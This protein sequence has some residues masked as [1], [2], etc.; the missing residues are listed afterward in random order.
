MIK[1]QSR[2][3]IDRYR[4]DCAVLSPSKWCHF[5]EEVFCHFK[6]YYLRLNRKES[7]LDL[8]KWLDNQFNLIKTTEKKL[9]LHYIKKTLKKNILVKV[10]LGYN[11][12]STQEKVVKLIKTHSFQLNV[13][14]WKEKRI[15]VYKNCGLHIVYCILQYL[16]WKNILDRRISIIFKETSKSKEPSLCRFIFLD[17]V[18]VLLTIFLWLKVKEILKLLK[19]QK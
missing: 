3:S 2:G 9:S 11:D 5:L 1:T 6:G 8:T 15:S 4:C 19:L 13:I 7:D 17:V 16:R 18:L 14:M 12:A 10:E